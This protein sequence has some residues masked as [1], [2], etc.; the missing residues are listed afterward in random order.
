[1]TDDR[2]QTTDNR[3]LRSGRRQDWTDYESASIEPEDTDDLQV[4]GEMNVRGEAGGNGDWGGVYVQLEI[5]KWRN[6]R[7]GTRVE[8]G[9]GEGGS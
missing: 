9:G 4:M 5:G 1:M 2:W 6:W 7:E 3:H 8:D